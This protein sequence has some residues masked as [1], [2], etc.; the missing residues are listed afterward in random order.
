MDE[1]IPDLWLSDKEGAL[2]ADES[3]IVVSVAEKAIDRDNFLIPVYNHWELKDEGEVK[4]MD[5]FAVECVKKLVIRLL[6]HGKKVL[7]HCDAGIDR[8]PFIAA[9]VLEARGEEF[10]DA[11]AI[12]RNRHP[13]TMEHFEWK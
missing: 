6:E 7:V 11:Y 12:V 5:P 4:N 10:P 3:F 8:S 2:E 1:I 9:V 13:Q